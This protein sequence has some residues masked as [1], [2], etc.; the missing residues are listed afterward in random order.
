MMA[1]TGCS[2]WAKAACTAMAS[3]T[4]T[5]LY[6]SDG[7][8]WDGRIREGDPALGMTPSASRLVV[9]LAIATAVVVAVDHALP[10]GARPWFGGTIAVVETEI[11]LHNFALA[12]MPGAMTGATGAR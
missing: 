7:A 12:Q 2:Q 8:R 1:V 9:S 5:T 6:M 4:A 10:T 11:A 3:D